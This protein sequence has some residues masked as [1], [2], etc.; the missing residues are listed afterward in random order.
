METNPTYALV[1]R[2]SDSNIVLLKNVPGE[3]SGRNHNIHENA[4]YS[5][6]IQQLIA[7]AAVLKDQELGNKLI[8]GIIYDKPYPVDLSGYE[9]TEEVECTIRKRKGVCNPKEDRNEFEDCLCRHNGGIDLQKNG[10]VV[11]TKRD[12][13][14]PFLKYDFQEGDVIEVNGKQLT[15]ERIERVTHTVWP[16][17]MSDHSVMTGSGFKLLKRLVSITT[18]GESQEEL[19][20][21]LRQEFYY[22]EQIRPELVSNRLTELMKEF[23]ITRK[24][25]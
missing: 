13:G 21:K 25:K 22:I 24:I 3:P 11:L 14:N 16:Y 8:D 2:S 20:T 23:T 7:S 9:V 15:I 10:I 5:V 17:R 12:G 6:A 19:F 4:A 18:E 1:L